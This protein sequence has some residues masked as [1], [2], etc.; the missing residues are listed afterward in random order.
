[1][2][3]NGKLSFRTFGIELN[4]LD[5]F[6]QPNGKAEPQ[7]RV[8]GAASLNEYTNKIKSRRYNERRRRCR[9]Q[10]VLGGIC[11]KDCSRC[12]SHLA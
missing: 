6:G 10:R 8:G 9:L 3:E 2:G 12:S 1:M 7:R 4:D 5:C 11:V